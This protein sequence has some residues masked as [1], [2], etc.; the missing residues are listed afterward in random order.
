MKKIFPIQ[1]ETGCVLKWAWSTIYLKQGT[2]ASCHRTNQ[3]K[4][5]PNNFADFHNHPDKLT[6]REL[7]LE[8]KWP[9]GGCQYCE[10]IEQAGGMSDRLNHLQQEDHD[11]NKIPVELFENPKQ[12]RV[13]PTILEIYFNNTC[14]MA[15]V[16]CGS[17]YSTKWEEENRQFGK[18]DNNGVQIGN[19]IIP[20]TPD[21]N[22][23]LSDFW[24]YLEV[25]YTSIRY[26][27]VLGGEPFFQT[28]F[29]QCLD[30]WEAHPNPDLAFNIITNLKVAPKKFHQYIN[31]FER[32]VKNKQI[33]R[34]Q[35]TGSLDAWGPEEEY[36]RWGLNLKEWEENFTY[37]LD[38]PWIVLTVNSAITPL[39]IKGLPDLI[40][41]INEWQKQR[42]DNLEIFHSFMSAISPNWLVPEIFG[43]GVFDA[44]FKRIL[45]VMPLNNT[46]DINSKEHMAGIFKQI[47][48]T[49]RDLTR[50]NQLKTY[51]TELDRRRGTSWPQVFPW[52][53]Q[54]F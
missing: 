19:N 40:L 54:E 26:F 46:F 2:T 47:S 36:V 41:R 7:M 37:L 29:D 25:N 49:P 1:T 12:T 17:H 23:M 28:E 3:S 53:N 30:F 4:I 33:N 6:A 39:T 21:Y 16:Y 22:R 5:D 42:Q 32:M 10:K 34:L 52:L 45:E 14:N 15:C 43:T 35:I 24:Q 20:S 8:G 48:S 31:R 51:L 50:I 11:L 18:F 9:K 27:Q 44:D 38:K 13:V